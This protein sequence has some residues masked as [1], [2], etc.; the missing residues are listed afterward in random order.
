MSRPHCPSSIGWAFL[1]AHILFP[2][3]LTHGLVA[4]EVLTY[5]VMLD[6]LQLGGEGADV[7]IS[8][9][10]VRITEQD[11]LADFWSANVNSDG[12]YLEGFIVDYSM[13]NHSF[14]SEHEKSLAVGEY[15]STNWARIN[16]P[17]VTVMV[18]SAGFTYAL[19]RDVG[20]ATD[21]DTVAVSPELGNNLICIASIIKTKDNATE[22]NCHSQWSDYAYE[23]LQEKKENDAASTRVYIRMEA[24]NS[25]QAVAEG[26]T[27]PGVIAAIVCSIFGGILLFCLRSYRKYK[28]RQIRIIE[29]ERQVRRN[30]AI[31]SFVTAHTRNE[32]APISSQQMKQL[33]AYI[34]TRENRNKLLKIWHKSMRGINQ[35]EVSQSIESLSVPIQEGGQSVQEHIKLEGENGAISTV[36]PTVQ[37]DKESPPGR[38]EVTSSPAHL[39]LPRFLRPK[40]API[41]KSIDIDE[42]VLPD[43][44]SDI[45]SSALYSAYVNDLASTSNREPLNTESGL[46]SVD[47]PSCRICLDNFMIG[48]KIRLLRCRHVFHK[49]CVDYWL[50]RICG[51]CPICKKHA[52]GHSVD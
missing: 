52:L 28:R 36:P 37:N 29:T 32:I 11:E 18:V 39:N 14:P 20:Q 6:F 5:R 44:T 30:R 2:L 31:T 22:R 12:S 1:L 13:I 3:F 48:D 41:S 26:G 43:S 34:I 45:S 21:K 19:A 9:T 51:Q 46:S 50:L 16:N 7:L 8:N 42:G 35:S 23:F 27:K 38:I 40:S 47:F 4:G 24:T 10:T 15:N 49:G 17:N 33:K 25:A